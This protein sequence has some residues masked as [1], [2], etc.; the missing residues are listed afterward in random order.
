MKKYSYLLVIILALSAIL[1]GCGTKKV[2]LTL[3]KKNQ[4][5]PDYVLTSSDKVKNTYLMAAKYPE[6]LANVPC[7]CGCVSDGHMSNLNCFVSK[8]GPNNA[9]QAWDQHGI[10]CDVCVNIANDAVQMHQDGKSPK[11]IYELIQEK[12]SSLGQPTPTPEPAK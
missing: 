4:P 7:Y 12:Y 1:A 6:V 9:V 2:D 10:G 5:L 8:M 3:D 11:E